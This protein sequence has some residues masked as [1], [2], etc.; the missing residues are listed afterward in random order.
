MV[1]FLIDR[2]P[3]LRLESRGEMIVGALRTWDT[4]LLDLLLPH[5]ADATLENRYF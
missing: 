3:D 2:L 4:E 1:K 5:G